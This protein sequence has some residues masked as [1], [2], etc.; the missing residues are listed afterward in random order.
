[1][2]G[3]FPVEHGLIS[4]CDTHLFTGIL[5]IYQVHTA[6]KDL[7]RFL[8]HA[9]MNDDSGHLLSIKEAW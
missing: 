5:Y 3:V 9:C 8:Y 2:G 7:L 6:V 1:M 4:S